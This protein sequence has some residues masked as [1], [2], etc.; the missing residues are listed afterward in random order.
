MTLHRTHLA[1]NPNARST[2]SLARL[3]DR[4][5]GLTVAELDAVAAALGQGWC[6]ARHRDLD[7]EAMAMVMAASPADPSVAHLQPTWVIHREGA[8]LRLDVCYADTY[9][10]HGAYPALAPL[11]AGLHAAIEAASRN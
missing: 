3:M 4:D 7:G 1:G 8:L 5:A 6:M 11:L 10:R 2:A 9:T